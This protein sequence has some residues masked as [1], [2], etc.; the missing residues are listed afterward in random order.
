MRLPGP[1]PIKVVIS[2]VLIAAAAV[3]LH[4]VYTWMGDTFL[5]TGGGVG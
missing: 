5:D 2:I 3:V 4:F 1:I